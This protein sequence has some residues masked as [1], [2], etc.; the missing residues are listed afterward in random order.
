M[1]GFIECGRDIAGQCGCHNDDA[2]S[3]GRG[4]VD[5]APDRGDV[6]RIVLV[7]LIKD[8]VGGEN[9]HRLKQK[10]RAR[11]A[12]NSH[13]MVDRANHDRCRG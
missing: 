7:D 8:Q 6:L 3:A 13:E 2:T 9:P 4:L 12:G 11:R 1:I 5:E 10:A